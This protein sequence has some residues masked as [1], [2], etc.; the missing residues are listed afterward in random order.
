[1][2]ELETPP[3]STPE[4]RLRA[5]V[6]E[7]AWSDAAAL[8]AE[9]PA[10]TP[11]SA[12]LATHAYKA[13]TMLKDE[14]QAE[15]W[16][17]RLLTLAPGNATF[18]RN[19]GVL[20]QKRNDWAG[21]LACY[22]RACELRPDLAP[23]R[24]AMATALYQ[25]GDYAAAAT[26][27]V[28]ALQTD[29]TQR[30]WWVRLARARVHL[31][32]LVG[33]ADAFGQA[34][35][36][37]DD[38]ALRGARDELLRQIRTGSR[39]ASSSYYDTVFAESPKYA[40]DGTDSEYA[41]VWARVLAGL[42]E[43]G[44]Q[45]ILDLGCGP[46][47]FAQYLAA[48][49]PD[50]TYT[51]LDFSAVA[52]A[53]ARQRC[54]QFLFEQ[55]ELPV[56]DFANLPPFDTVVCTEVLEH[57]ENDREILAALPAGTAIS[58]SVPN[59]DAFGHVRLFRDEAE[60]RARYGVLF[61]ELAIEAFQLSASN[62]LW[63]MRGRRS[64]N[65]LPADDDAGRGPVDRVL[66]GDHVVESVLWTDGTRY[67]EDFLGQFGLPCVSV[68]ESATLREPHVALR[69][70]VD[71]SIEN[72]FAMATLE[73]ELGLRSTYFLLHPDGRITDRNYFGHIEGGQL[74]ID[75]RLFEW[76]SRLIDLGHEVALHND[77]ISLAL[78]TRR[79]PAEFL[80]QIVEAFTRKGMP[81]AGSVAHGSRTC[82]DL[83]YMNY[84]I[85]EEL[86]HLHVAVD[87]QNSPELFDRFNEDRVVQD[88]HEVRKFNLR[89]ADYGLKYEANFV[90][91]EVYVSDS[92][93]HWSV[94]RQRGQDPV[95]LTRF[96]RHQDAAAMRGHLDALL[97]DKQP[98]SAVQCL[99]HA[100][101]WGPL[102]QFNARSV[103][104]VRK[105]R[106]QQFG[107][108]R[109]ESMKQRLRGM[110]NVIAAEGTD[111]FDAYDQQYSTKPQLYNVATTV[112]RFVE[113][114]V[115]GPA[116]GARQLLE[117]GCGQG[118]F[119][120]SIRERLQTAQ[121]GTEVRAL[122][123]DGSPAAI[124]TCAGRY[125]ELQW[126][127]DSLEHFLAHHERPEG[128]YDLVL[129]KTG[130]IFIPT[131]AEGRAFFEAMDR[132][133]APGGLFVY[134]ASRHYYEENLR[135]KNYAGWSHHWME[136]AAEHF[137]LIL[138]DDDD[139]PEMRGYYK[140]VYRKPVSRVAQ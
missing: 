102:L 81:L 17:D 73:H 76:A 113:T 35:A 32:E 67:V 48:A 140:R 6:A 94:W 131:E 110:P 83:G 8:A 16:L 118:D 109:R 99:I 7:Q 38:A 72:A 123:V 54:P 134:V 10:E 43:Q 14:V 127:A 65:A 13:F 57:V 69:H 59:F 132:L 75:P 62:I 82:R 49:W 11:I 74:V 115:K 19:K 86:Q 3:P 121:P 122:G 136:L 56:A 60:V 45:R 98:A 68:Q 55:R 5:L 4:A 130:A 138:N 125:P 64:A 84:Q 36:L 117:V 12:A 135:K 66:L 80:E 103:A 111:R 22:R 42:R 114:L 112:G 96:E 95:E 119:I 30:G 29:A 139:L 137:E 37:Q 61:D 116:A 33:A 78:A 133:M 40:V 25:T 2:S 93:A 58:A 87:Y 18:Q 126:A 52:V 21:A 89:M 41:P 108:R 63:I 47:Q 71:W 128:G 34:L 1:M 104:A 106:N 51:G 44:A 120:A 129:D 79:Q 50:I 20:L 28:E 53:K 15:A 39:G 90:P 24:G 91:W 77:L 101:H 97:R 31:G 92:S 23:Y 70:D 27:F 85:F 88:G 107:A 9:L 100:C 124:V 26:A 46:G 105:R